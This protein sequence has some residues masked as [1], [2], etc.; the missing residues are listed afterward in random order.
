M[1]S[2]PSS[3]TWIWGYGSLFSTS[4]QKHLLSHWFL[5][6][7]PECCKGNTTKTAL[8]NEFFIL[9]YVETTLCDSVLWPLSAGKRRIITSP[10]F[11]FAVQPYCFRMSFLSL[12]ASFQKRCEQT[13]WVF[14]MRRCNYLCILSRQI[15]EN[16]NNC[17]SNLTLRWHIFIHMVFSYIYIKTIY[18]YMYSYLQVKGNGNICWNP[19]SV[20]V[21]WFV[22]KSLLNSSIPKNVSLFAKQSSPLL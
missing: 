10:D 14:S 18:I 19:L 15:L 7:R 13:R 4:R 9:Q 6:R 17:P 3:T 2:L 20:V 12:A 22:M 5:L 16:M 11:R 21:F 1:R 8:I